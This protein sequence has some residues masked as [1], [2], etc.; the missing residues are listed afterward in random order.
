VGYVSISAER[1][2][3]IEDTSDRERLVSNNSVLAFEG[4]LKAVVSQLENERD[5]DRLKASDEEQLSDLFQ[6]MT[7]DDVLAEL[8]AIADEGAPAADAVPMLQEFGKKLDSIRKAVK[9]RFTYYSRLATVGTIAQAIVHEIRNRTTIFGS[10]I[11]YISDKGRS[12]VGALL[13]AKVKQATSA[14]D[15]LEQLADRFAPLASRAFRRGRRDS[16]IEESIRRCLSLSIVA[17]EIKELDIQVCVPSTR[18][19]VA[20][21]PGELDIIVLNLILNSVYWLRQV[22]TKRRLEFRISRVTS[23]QRVKLFVHDSGPGVAK[24]D[25]KKI[26]LPGVT[27]KP[28]GIGMGLTVACELVAAYGGQM[29]LAQPGKLGGASFAFDMPLKP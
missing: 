6:D 12:V 24:G 7:A 3:S 23:G 20:V 22:K 5:R 10:F 15:S 19:R 16:V 28:G 26:F 17:K 13:P 21:D 8:V 9:K 29:Y 27:R 14:V 25:A 11:R 4:I 2:P 18:R 1:N